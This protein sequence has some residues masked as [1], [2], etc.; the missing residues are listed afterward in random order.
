MG[1]VLLLSLEVSPFVGAL[2]CGKFLTIHLSSSPVIGWALDGALL[3]LI[4]FFVYGFPSKL[5][6]AFY[7]Q[8]ASQSLLC[9]MHVIPIHRNVQM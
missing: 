7:P 3:L 8:S 2:F 4:L 5:L 6:F 1:H 9:L